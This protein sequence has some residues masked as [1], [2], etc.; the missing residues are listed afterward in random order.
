TRLQQEFSAEPVGRLAEQ[1][2]RGDIPE[3]VPGDDRG[4]Q[5]EPVRRNLQ[6]V[7]DL[8]QQADDDV[9]VEG[10]EDDR[11]AA[12]ADGE[13]AKAGHAGAVTVTGLSTSDSVTSTMALPGK[14]SDALTGA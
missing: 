10:A 9:G 2:H 13:R 6:L 3:E 12:G 5:L 4:D 7:D 8:A 1:R 11:Q 14:P